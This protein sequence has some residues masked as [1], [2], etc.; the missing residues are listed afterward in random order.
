MIGG[1]DPNDISAITQAMVE[2]ASVVSPTQLVD[3]MD[4]PDQKICRGVM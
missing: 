4:L 1:Y 3:S 2:R